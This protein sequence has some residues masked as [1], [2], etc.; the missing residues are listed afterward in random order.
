MYIPK[1]SSSVD[2]NR[3]LSH[4]TVVVISLLNWLDTRMMRGI[5]NNSI[6]SESFSPRKV[7]N[8]DSQASFEKDGSFFL[9]YWYLPWWV[10]D[11][12]HRLS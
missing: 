11:L 2:P 9:R 10:N 8:S 3:S 1:P 7:N 6:F 12:C 4:R 5:G